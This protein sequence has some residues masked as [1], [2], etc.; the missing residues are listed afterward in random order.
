M[1]YRTGGAFYDYALFCHTG[2]SNK[3]YVELCNV[4]TK[5]LSPK[6]VK[7]LK[8]VTKRLIPLLVISI[9]LT[10]A[11]FLGL[12]KTSPN[13]T[14]EAYLVLMKNK[15]FHQAYQLVKPEITAPTLTEDFY[16]NW[17]KNSDTQLIS[18]S[19]LKTNWRDFWKPASLGTEVQFSY[20]AKYRS[21]D[22]TKT[23]RETLNLVQIGSYW[24][25]FPKWQVR[26]PHENLT[27][28]SQ[29]K[30]A[31]IKL[32]GVKLS[33]LTEQIPLTVEVFAG[34]HQVEVSSPDAQPIVI[35]KVRNHAKVPYLATKEDLLKTTL[36]NFEDAWQAAHHPVVAPGTNVDKVPKSRETPPSPTTLDAVYQSKL[37]QFFT[38]GSPK[39]QD[40]NNILQDRLSTKKGWLYSYTSTWQQQSYEL[41][42]A[43]LLD[44]ET[45]KITVSETWL[46][47]NTYTDNTQSSPTPHGAAWSVTMK[48]VG[49]KWLIHQ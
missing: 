38:P 25:I 35:K 27:I 49:D 37:A 36:Q 34:Y 44:P 17:Q 11:Y 30:G 45:V 33:A 42:E 29:T 48:K 9:L 8:R 24:G 32:D 23:S 13:K 7:L 5:E 40:F 41:T 3:V 20:N 6:G 39:L 10:S 12:N 26:L 4:Q 22:K 1:P 18:Y 2:R 47:T 21:E 43:T 15:D 16:T 28:T 31:Q 14:A 46:V 19:N